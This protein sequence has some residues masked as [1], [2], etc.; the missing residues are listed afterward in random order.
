MMDTQHAADEAA[1]RQQ[2]DR[3]AGAIRAGD[4]ER[5]RPIFAPDIVSF[6]VGPPLQR[7]GV[8]G[9]LQN[10]AEA[11]ALFQLPLEYE[12][13]DLTLTLGRDV[14]FAHGFGR[15]SGTLKN[16]T[17]SSGF[18]VRYTVCLRKIAG[19]WLIV[20][21]HVSAPLDFESGSAVLNLEP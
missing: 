20:H 3:L 17:S 7:V 11:F 18:W 4:L 10:W 2:I 6:D 15:L 9:K 19:S 13:R 12:I 16:G 1:V 5:L 21:D 14:A 8:E